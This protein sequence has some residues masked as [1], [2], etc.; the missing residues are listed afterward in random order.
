ML[1]TFRFTAG[2]TVFIAA[3][4]IA[5]ADPGGSGYRRTVARIMAESS[6]RIGPPRAPSSPPRLRAP[7]ARLTAGGRAHAGPAALPRAASAAPSGP[8]APQTL[9][10]NFRGATLADTNAFPPDSSGAAGPS[11]FLVGVNGR[12]RTFGKSSGSADGVLNSDLD[13]F[14]APVTGGNPTATPRVR[15]DRLSGRWIVTVSNFGASFA[16]NR[17]LIAVSDA[18]SNGI[19]SNTTVWTYF[20]FE[21]DLVPPTGDTDLFFDSPTLGVDANA[22]VIGGNLF[23]V[24]GNFQGTTVHVVRKSTLLSGAGGDLTPNSVQ[25][26]RNLTGTVSGTGPYAPQGVD[27]PTGASAT[28]SWAVG[29]DNAGFGS[30]VLRRISYSGLGVWPPT[31]ISANLVLAVD[32]TWLPLTVPHL[33]NTGGAAGELD[34]VDDRLGS[35]LRRGD[36]IWTA[37]NIAVDASGTGSSSGTRDGSRWYEI[38]VSGV[39]PTLAQ[40]GTLFDAS[41]VNPRFYWIPSIAVSGQGHAA[42]ST[43]VAGAARHIDGASAGR[44]ADDPPGTLQ[45]PLL[46][47]TSSTA[48]NPPADPG[49]PRRW[50]DYSHT[51]VDPDDDMTLWTI[52][53]YCDAT[54]SYG[55]RVAQMVAPPP[56]SPTSASPSVVDHGLSSVLVDVT[57]TPSAGSGFFDPGNG[58]PKRLQVSVSQGVTVNAVTYNGPTSITLDL[59]TVTAPNGPRTITVTNPDGQIVTSASGVLSIGFPGAPSLL[60]IAPTSGPADGNTVLSLTGSGFDAGATVKV[61]GVPATNVDIASDTSATATAPVLPPGT[62]NDVTVQNPDLLSGT[63]FSAFFADFL[64]VPQGDIFHA[65][66]EALFRS[67]VTAG[68]GSGNYC[69]NGAVTRAQMAVF[70]LKAKLGAAYA[71]P[72]C[73]GTVFD[74]VPCTGGNFDPWIEDLAARGITG[75]CG[76]NDYCPGNPVTRAQMAPFLLKTDLGS[77]YLPPDCTGTVFA[78]V[79]CTG[80]IFDAWIE[81]LAARGITG[82]CGGGNYCPDN[83]NTRGQMAAFLVITFGL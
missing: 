12:I 3:A 60:S 66:V 28:E 45:S 56:A 53:E 52:Q 5:A 48:Y 18:A 35:A 54:D 4:A 74:D 37:H 72:P 68:C 24:F 22:L 9:G 83:P 32:S 2:V 42:L 76:A 43:S 6:A 36:G 41:A 31:G 69:R 34:A 40:S 38:D 73:T 17:I 23:S 50:G 65:S 10:V 70:L 11:Q 59:N 67:G 27:D 25:A 1:K 7:R 81:D 80:G 82:G 39:S 62:L 79:P 29:V 61:G 8:S 47:T 16:N 30:L 14:F 55:V 51:N 58:F 20:F 78:D 75:G 57:A 44:L 21:H 33:G 46:L 49:P 63:L 15:Y 64:D 71:P 26:F 13:T 19:I 77:S